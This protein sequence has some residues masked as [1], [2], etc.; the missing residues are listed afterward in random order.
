MIL[1]NYIQHKGDK[2]IKI[3]QTKGGFY[4]KNKIN[5]FIMHDYFYGSIQHIQL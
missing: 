4:E 5:N 2:I 1:Y 3:V